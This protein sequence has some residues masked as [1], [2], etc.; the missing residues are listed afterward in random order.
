MDFDLPA[1]NQAACELLADVERDVELLRAAGDE[2]GAR[3]ATKRV[4]QLRQSL[5][6]MSESPGHAKGRKAK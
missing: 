5:A 2:R 1:L 4:E 6:R 3:R